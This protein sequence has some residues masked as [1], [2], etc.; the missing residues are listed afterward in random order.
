MRLDAAGHEGLKEVI[1]MISTAPDP[2][3]TRKLG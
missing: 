2:V 3:V 1:Y